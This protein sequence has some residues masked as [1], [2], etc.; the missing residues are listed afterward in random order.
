MA[1]PGKKL[2]SYDQD[3][4][5]ILNPDT[6]YMK[7]A[8]RNASLNDITTYIYQSLMDFQGKWKPTDRG[9]YTI[10]FP[11][12]RYLAIG[13]KIYNV[14]TGK[15]YI[16]AEIVGD[17]TH[18]VR[19][20][21]QGAVAPLQG[22]VLALEDKNTVNFVSAYS[23]QYQDQPIADWRDTVIYRV[24]RREPGT[25]G[26]HPFDPPTEIKPRVREYRI[27]DDHPD[28]HVVVMGQWYDNLLQFDC[29]S[30][31]NNT[32][33][34]LV[35]W[36]EDFMYKYT[37]VWKKNGVSE[38]LY[39]MR[40]TDEEVSKWRNDLAVRN[41]IYYF[42]TEKIVSI[43][44]YDFKQINMYLELDNALPSGFYGVIWG[45][46]VPASG[47]MGIMDHG[48]RAY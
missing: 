48:F 33:D 41:V 8:D 17:R 3:P 31:Y 5:F 24:K 35:E 29:W 46:Q 19:L 47:F 37:W 14:T 45:N 38:V 10:E 27:D 30:K 12:A 39:W 15:V 22:D 18:V 9:A 28:C 23:R 11:N 20:N 34:T 6:T 25:T 40:N 13:D 36:F 32:A 43:K 4:Y 44:E 7:Q 2:E 26:K 16:I 42:R 1:T 21:T